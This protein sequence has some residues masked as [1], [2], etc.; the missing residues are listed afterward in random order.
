LASC[1]CL[2]AAIA[3]VLPLFA[4]GLGI[5]TLKALGA[6]H[7]VTVGRIKL[8]SVNI[9]S[10][11]IL[12]S[13]LYS[14]FCLG[15]IL[16]S[17]K[18]TVSFEIFFFSFWVLSLGLE[19]LRFLI[20]QFAALGEPSAWSI[21]V[22][23]IVIGGRIMGLL[24]FFVA[25]LYAA[26]FRNDKLGSAIGLLAVAAWALA[27]VMP[28]DTGVYETVMLMRPGYAG[29]AMAL[30]AAVGLVTVANFF[31][32]A[33]AT[34]EAS[35]RTVA[36]GAAAALIGQQLVVSQWNPIMMAVGAALLVFGSWLFVSRLHAYYLWQ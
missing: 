10:A 36:F 12:L 5:R 1:L 15:G 2:A 18:K 16:A 7:E 8:D 14:T 32:A 20:V 33:V 17:F 30:S 3:L 26:G 31:Y 27:Y 4:K 6:Y 34:G 29:L 21:L 13:A 35:Y 22:T 25:G 24:S 11:G 23:R 28:I 19:S 9:V